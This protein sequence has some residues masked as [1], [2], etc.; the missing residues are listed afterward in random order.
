MEKKP[1]KS[2]LFRFVTLRSPQLPD[3][4]SKEFAF[5]A[6]ENKDVSI[7]HRATQGITDQKQKQTALEQAYKDPMQFLPIENA[8]EL[9]KTKLYQFSSWLM[10]NK[11]YLSPL[12]IMQNLAVLFADDISGPTAAPIFPSFDDVILS[13]KEEPQLWENLYYQTI[14]KTSTA[15]RETI[16]QMLIAN[17]FLK[18]FKTY[19]EVNFNAMTPGGSVGGGRTEPGSGVPKDFTPGSEAGAGNPLEALEFTSEELREFT[20]RANA[21]VVIP[22]EV[23]YAPKTEESVTDAGLS[24]RVSEYLRKQAIVDKAQLRLA[25]YKASLK[26]LKRAEIVYNKE[27]VKKREA[28][29]QEYEAKVRESQSQAQLTK[30]TAVTEKTVVSNEDSVDAQTVTTPSEEITDITL[31]YTKSPEIIRIPDGSTEA[32]TA[33]EARILA[34]LSPETIGLF[35]STEFEIF[36]TFAEVTSVLE[37]RI[38][39]ENLT[40]VDNTPVGV[41]NDTINTEGIT[42]DVADSVPYVYSISLHNVMFQASSTF[43]I[44]IHIGDSFRK[45]TEMSYKMLDDKG[46]EIVSADAFRALAS[47]I[48]SYEKVKIFPLGILV[49]QS[50]YTIEGEITLSDNTVLSFSSK[51]EPKFNTF[52]LEETVVGIAKVVDSDSGTEHKDEDTEAPDGV[53][54]GVSQLGIADFRRVEQEVCCYVPGEVSHIENIMAREYKERST[55]N[56]RIS[57]VTTEQS[58]ER[59]TENLTDTT[60]TERN[61]LQS[62]A[63]S[64]VNEDN[65]T[66]F[67]ANASVSGKL[68]FADTMFSAGT[69]Y[70]SSSSSSRSDSNL[71]AQTYA[72]EVTE[73]ALERVVEKVSRKRTSRIVK[74]F[75]E[76]NTHGFDNRKGDKHV[77]GVYRWVDIIYKNSMVNYGKRLMYEFA[78]P[79]PAKFYIDCYLNGDSKKS[80]V[81]NGSIIAPQKPKHPSELRMGLLLPQGLLSPVNLHKDN[82]QDIA[83]LYNAEVKPEPLPIKRIT[84]GF[85]SNYYKGGKELGWLTSEVGEM[86]IPEGYEVNTAFASVSYNFHHN[87]KEYPSYSIQIGGKSHHKNFNRSSSSSEGVREDE[88]NIRFEY[89]GGVQGKLAIAY[90]SY[91][92]GTIAISVSAECSRTREYYEQWQNETYNAILN[93]Y[94]ERVR[95]YN[96]FMQGQSLEGEEAEKQREFS[97]QL[98][99][100]IEKREIKRIAVDLMTKPF[101]LTTSKS[102]YKDSSAFVNRNK[103]FQ[104]HAEVVKF[105]EQAFD[106][107]IMAY[108]FYPYFYK[109]GEEAWV[110]SFDYEN[111]NDPIFKAFL[112]SGMARAVVPVRPGFEKAVNWFMN[113]G[114]IWNGQGMV[115]DTEDELYVSVAEEMLNPIG[116]VEG[117]WET[118]VPTALT[119]LQADSVVLD[120][121]GLPCNLNCDDTSEFG[122]SKNT[123]GGNT[124][125][126]LEGVGFD[127]V[128]QDNDVR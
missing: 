21:S 13:D 61:E 46:V 54:Y 53:I 50:S 25:Q 15:V 8:L 118:R 126:D 40:I 88:Q 48:S 32:P 62:E 91:D 101:G 125:N 14:H 107:E 7:A 11:N 82:Y 111:S 5:V 16:I 55:R 89:L 29:L 123:L 6:L 86:D 95:E 85:G 64:V 52:T 1:I 84:T 4:K 122:T 49:G 90:E 3:E 73:R 97:S 92:T 45:I 42:V 33:S 12:S 114:E 98:N 36:D 68:G 109:A 24:S 27:E 100:G 113:T 124:S 60:T 35:N 76:N 120:E 104:N 112:Q 19:V 78:I 20:L 116:E 10:R 9:R 103:E 30:E 105:F 26:E 38:E 70:N 43:D 127:T 56:L 58:R 106:W 74:E 83:A 115:T 102:N 96:E 69:N 66:S 41:I 67:G 63:S 18:A 87:D 75:E 93:A 65:V 23:L 59:E 72:Q 79:E 121:G 108:T 51:I 119:I 34:Q 128:G 28:A 81:N 110:K 39:E 22:K 80:T 117:T 44:N 17:K 99:R 47:Q 77:T 31:A 57:D 2:N 94:N 71:Q 37:D